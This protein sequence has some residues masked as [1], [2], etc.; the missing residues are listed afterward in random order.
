LVQ[1]LGGRSIIYASLYLFGFISV[2]GFGYNG[3]IIKG[4]IKCFGWLF[5]V[6]LAVG[7]SEEIIFRGYLLQNM[8]DG[9]GLI[10]AI[11][12]S[13]ILYGL[14]HMANPNASILSGSLIAFIGFLRIY[15]YIR[16]NQLWLSMGMHAGWNFFQG[17]IFG[18]QVS[19]METDKLI[20]HT[21]SGKIWIT[22]GVFGPE[23]GII[24]VPVVIFAIGIVYLY[25]K[26]QKI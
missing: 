12:I 16:T 2:E 6:G 21:L 11:V 26:K 18:F 14:L 4:L 1:L 13:C 10:L 23:A 9:M 8:R 15:G 20:N 17:P 3:N 5:V 7:W 25:T 22:G 24:V 19:G